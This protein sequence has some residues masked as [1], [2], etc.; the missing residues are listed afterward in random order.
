M[1][2]ILGKTEGN[3]GVNVLP[4][5]T[6]LPRYAPGFRQFLVCRPPQP[7]IALPS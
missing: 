2:A 6:R 3:G 7:T 5:S 1:I 4:E